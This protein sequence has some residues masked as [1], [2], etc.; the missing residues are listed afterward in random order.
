MCAI[1]GV[2]R[3]GEWNIGKILDRLCNN[4]LVSKRLPVRIVLYV[5]PAVIEAP[6]RDTACVGKCSPHGSYTT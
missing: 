3:I 4:V 6:V 5:T 2:W 1:P